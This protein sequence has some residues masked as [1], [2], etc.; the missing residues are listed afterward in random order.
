MSQWHVELTCEKEELLA[1][2]STTLQEQACSVNAGNR[3]CYYINRGEE[4]RLAARKTSGYYLLASQFISLTDVN[5][6]LNR[7]NAILPFLNALVKVRI[8]AFAPPL[9]IDDVFRLDAEGRMIWEIA[10]VVATRSSLA[11]K[12]QEATGQ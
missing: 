4:P 3:D 2:L 12:L 11:Q 8:S 6:V 7:A 5:E 10:T 1:F 9:E